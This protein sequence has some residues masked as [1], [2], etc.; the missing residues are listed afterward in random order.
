ME[1]INIREHYKRKIIN[2][3]NFNLG[4]HYVKKTIY[5]KLQRHR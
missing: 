2:H 4:E 3:T 1:Q 5:K